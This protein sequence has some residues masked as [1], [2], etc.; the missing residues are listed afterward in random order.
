MDVNLV[1]LALHRTEFPSIGLT[2]HQTPIVM[3]ELM[4]L[5]IVIVVRNGQTMSFH[6]AFRGPLIFLSK[7]TELPIAA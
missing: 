4:E 7:E 5:L 3:S 6:L 1:A 2:Q